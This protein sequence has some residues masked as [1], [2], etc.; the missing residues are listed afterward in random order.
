M[1]GIAA[2]VLTVG[3]G[4]G[5]QNQVKSQINS[6]GTNLLTVSPGSSTSS[7]GF[8]QG[9]GSASTLTEADANALTSD[10]RGPRHQGGSPG[11]VQLRGAH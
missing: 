7:S 9:F 3:L 1:I 2:V 8:R 11:Q 10:D 6:L 5:A 4:Q